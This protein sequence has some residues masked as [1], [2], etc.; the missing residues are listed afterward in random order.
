MNIW[1][2]LSASC[3]IQFVGMVIAVSLFYYQ[4]GIQRMQLGDLLIRMLFS[5]AVFLVG[6]PLFWLVGI[7]SDIR[8]RMKVKDESTR[9]VPMDRHLDS[10]GR[11][12]E[13]FQTAMGFQRLRLGFK[14][15]TVTAA[16]LVVVAVA[17]SAFAFVLFAVAIIYVL[18]IHERASGWKLLS[19]RNTYTVM[20]LCA[21]IMVCSPVTFVFLALLGAQKYTLLLPLLIWGLYTYVENRSIN[22]LDKKFQL[23][24]RPA[25]QAALLGILALAVAYCYEFGVNRL[26]LFLYEVPFQAPIFVFAFPFLIASSVLLIIKLEPASK[27][28]KPASSQPSNEFR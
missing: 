9:A 17:Y 2:W 21:I 26:S 5:V 22:E 7:E 12:A 11:T 8:H 10:S 14:L 25:R 15:S 6:T 23:N 16:L 28:W 27:Q 4:L 20:W 3:A 1:K 24:L 18:S 19:F 13:E